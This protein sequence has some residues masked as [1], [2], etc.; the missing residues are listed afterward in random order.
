MRDVDRRYLREFIPAM[1]GYVITVLLMVPLVRH[2]D[3]VIARAGLALLPLIPTA[4]FVRAMVRRLL[5]GDELERRVMLESIAI[6]AL[7]IGMLSFTAGF[8]EAAD[9]FRI[10]S[11]AML[12]VFPLMM[13]SFGAAR[14]WAQ[15]KYSAE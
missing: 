2:T 7:T 5:G 12:W 14:C 6:S 8:L 11:G 3:S 13:G 10:P 1:L 9:V 4:F 15:R